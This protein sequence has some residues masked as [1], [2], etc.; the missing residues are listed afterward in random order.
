MGLV[1]AAA[2]EETAIVG[3]ENGIAIGASA[4]V[5]AATVVTVVVTVGVEGIVAMMAGLRDATEIYSTTDEATA[6]VIGTEGAETETETRIFSRKTDVV[7]ARPLRPRNESLPRIS[8]TSCP[9]S[10]A[11]AA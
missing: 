7:G 6:V 10:S 8:P 2:A 11:S 4:V 1:A 9:S 5:T 3:N